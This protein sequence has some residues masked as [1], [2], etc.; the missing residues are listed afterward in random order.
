MPTLTHELTSAPPPNHLCQPPKYASTPATAPLKSLILT[1]L[2]PHLILSATHHAYAPAAPSRYDSDTATPT[3]SSPQLTM[4]TLS[5]N[6]HDI[7]LTLPPHVFPHPSLHSRRPASYHAYAPTEPSRY[8]SDSATPC[9]PSP[10]L[11]LQHP[12]H[13]PCLR[14][15]RTLKI[16][17]L[18]QNLISTLTP[19]YVFTPLPYLLCCLPSLCSHIRSIGYSGLLAYNTITEIC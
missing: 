15:H 7:P 8:A 1:L 12:R 16:C 6:P 17:L 18:W 4:L 13:L 19:P 2:H 5:P 11:M 9:L 3:S 10:I 14:S